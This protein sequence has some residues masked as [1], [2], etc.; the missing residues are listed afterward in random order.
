MELVEFPHTSDCK[1]KGGMGQRNKETCHDACLGTAA[2]NI[3]ENKGIV[4]RVCMCVFLGGYAC[5]LH[6]IAR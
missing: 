4:W 2:P 5:D 6:Y 1:K 3:E